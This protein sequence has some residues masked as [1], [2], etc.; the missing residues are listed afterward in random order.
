MV[1]LENEKMRENNFEMNRG[2]EKFKEE[3]GQHVGAPLAYLSASVIL[4]SDKT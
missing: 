2:N 3:I 1:V 4:I